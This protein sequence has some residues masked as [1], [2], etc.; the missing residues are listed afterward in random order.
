MNPAFQNKDPTLQNKAPVQACMKKMIFIMPAPMC[1]YSI[2]LWTQNRL[3][4][5]VGFLSPTIHSGQKQDIES[6]HLK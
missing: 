6:M 4:M 2:K 5:E 1:I 3:Y